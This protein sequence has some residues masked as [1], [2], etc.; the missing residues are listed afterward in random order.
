MKNSRNKNVY[1]G[2]IETADVNGGEVR[3]TAIITLKVQDINYI[4]LFLP[5]EGNMDM[6]PREMTLASIHLF[7]YLCVIAGKDNIAIAI[8]RDIEKAIRY[9]SASISRAKDQLKRMDYI[10]QK[11]S[12]VYMLNPELAVK[13]EGEKRKALADIYRELKHK[14]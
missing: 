14:V 11:A 10:R 6:R 12:N 13:V 4:K 8:T 7:D 2:S 1:A 9:S 3:R 5:S